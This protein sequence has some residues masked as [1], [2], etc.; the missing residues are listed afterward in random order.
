MGRSLIVLFV[1][2]S[3]FCYGHNPPSIRLLQVKNQLLDTIVE[4]ILTDEGEWYTVRKNKEKTF[5]SL[6][7]KE[8]EAGTYKI[9]GQFL[10]RDFDEFTFPGYYVL[11]YFYYKGCLV[12]VYSQT[13]L[14]G[15]FERKATMRKFD[16]MKMPSLERW[17]PAWFH[18]PAPGKNHFFCK[19]RLK[20]NFLE[21]RFPSD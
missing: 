13:E 14:A 16:F 10:D 21:C 4:R 9:Y 12:L 17:N 20:G 1:F 18:L 3:Y 15:L 11:G 19:Y 8:I 6:R 7:I 5:I 2:V